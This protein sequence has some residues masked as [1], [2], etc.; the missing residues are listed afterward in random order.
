MLFS[1]AAACVRSFLLLESAVLCCVVHACTHSGLG[2]PPRDLLSFF[3][4]FPAA[5][6]RSRYDAFMQAYSHVSENLNTIY[7]VNTHAKGFACPVQTDGRRFHAALAP[8][9]YVFVGD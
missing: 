8:T 3:L 2:P 9:F 7:K 5:P 1:L 6:P 4:P